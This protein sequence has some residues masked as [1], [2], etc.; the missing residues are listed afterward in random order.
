MLIIGLKS[1]DMEYEEYK[2]YKKKL[3]EKWMDENC[4]A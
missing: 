2:E 3:N 4:V 1:N